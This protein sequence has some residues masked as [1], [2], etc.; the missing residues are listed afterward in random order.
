MALRFLRLSTVV[1]NKKIK[2]TFRFLEKKKTI[3]NSSKTYSLS[4]FQHLSHQ[5]LNV[6]STRIEVFSSLKNKQK[7]ILTIKILADLNSE[8]FCIKHLWKFHNN[9]FNFEI[10]QIN[11]FL[12]HF[13]RHKNSVT[14]LFLASV[15]AYNL[16]FLFY[17]IC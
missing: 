1:F 9:F 5:C 8:V 2:L 7:K 10:Q 11:L 17:L 15:L 14:I 3:E 16:Q 12:A 4:D 13:N 6:F